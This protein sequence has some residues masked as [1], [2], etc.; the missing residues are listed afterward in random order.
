MHDTVDRDLVWKGNDRRSLYSFIQE[1]RESSG[2]RKREEKKDEL[3]GE[4]S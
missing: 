2:N 3:I 1:R 4:K